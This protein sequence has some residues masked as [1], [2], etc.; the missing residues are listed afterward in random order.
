VQVT[1]GEQ[2]AGGLDLFRVSTLGFDMNA[3]TVSYGMVVIAASSGSLRT[4]G[5]TCTAAPRCSMSRG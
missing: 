2:V 4:R 1:G 5:S 3:D